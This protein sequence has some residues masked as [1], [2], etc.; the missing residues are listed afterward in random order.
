MSTAK[1]LQVFVSSTFE[2]LRVERQAAV[3]A[4]L[5]AGHIPA[6]MELFAAGDESQMVVIRR[7]I[8]E[9]DVFMLILGQRYGSIE[10]ESQKSYVHL[11]YEYAVERHKPLF[12][13]VARDY[14]P[15]MSAEGAF[16]SSERLA[17]LRAL[18]QQRVVRSWSEANE[19][20][21]AIHETLADFA[22]RSDLGGWVRSDESV[23]V[24]AISEEL[25]RLS[26]ENAAL[27]E[28]LS[29]TAPRLFNG[30]TFE[31]LFQLLATTNFALSPPNA[32]NEF[33]A[34]QQ[35]A[36][37]LGHERP[38]SLHLF[39]YF[40]SQLVR[41][42]HIGTPALQVFAR[43]LEEAGLIELPYPGNA[44]TLFRLTDVGRQFLLCFRNAFDTRS[45][46]EF[47]VRAA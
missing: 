3:E 25:A 7:W 13:V 27:R 43:Q 31:E 40:S 30:L 46:E 29:A 42:T 10:P 11:E 5:S 19:I 26:Q 37:F 2:D 4:I 41:G 1:K 18:V 32:Q 36:G 22:R 47:R 6:G 34:L 23:N 14:S 24:G 12:A 8:D 9:S 17:G 28:R 16:A 35:I 45:I 39:W 15:S 33:Y 44:D 21:L 20:K 38:A